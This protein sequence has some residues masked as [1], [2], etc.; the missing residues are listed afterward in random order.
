LIGVSENWLSD[1]GLSSASDT[2][3][4]FAQWRDDIETTAELAQRLREAGAQIVLVLCHSNARYT[5]PLTSVPGVDFVLGGHEHIKEPADP[6]A[7]RWLISGWDFDDFSIVDFQI[8]TPGAA[9]DNITVAVTRVEVAPDQLLTESANMKLLQQLVTRCE[10][11]LAVLMREQIGETAVALQ[12]KKFMLRTQ[13][14]NVGSMMADAFQERLDADCALLIGGIISSHSLLPPGPITMENI[15]G[16]FPWEGTAVLIRLTGEQLIAAL[17]HGVSCLPRRDG[18]FPQVS[19]MKFCVDAS[20]AVGER[21]SNLEVAGAP[22]ELAREYRVATNDYVAKGGDEYIMLLGA[23]MLVNGESG[24]LIHDVVRDH[25]KK[26]GAGGP[27]SPQVE[28]RI[29]HL[30]GFRIDCEEEAGRCL[31][32]KGHDTYEEAVSRWHA[33]GQSEE[34]I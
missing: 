12:A 27:I 16:W 4:K 9:L 26:I 11:D 34:S 15:L 25:I 14:T 30:T 6:A 7:E 5:K 28:G 21:I 2:P 19:G 22:I 20:N 10:A 32:Q 18:R 29:R 13:E 3:D 1:A 8:P 24:P 33:V 23:P 31:V 17:E